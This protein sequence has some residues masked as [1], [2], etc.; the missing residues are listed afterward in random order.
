MTKKPKR[1]SILKLNSLALSLWPN[2]LEKKPN[3]IANENKRITLKTFAKDYGAKKDIFI[4]FFLF[5]Q[6]PSGYSKCNK[7]IRTFFLQGTSFKKT[8]FML[9]ILGRITLQN[10]SLR[11]KKKNCFCI[12]ILNRR[13]CAN[14]FWRKCIWISPQAKLL[15]YN[16]LD[17]KKRHWNYKCSSFL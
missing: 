12:F 4:F 3:R 13:F 14:Y 15:I 11:L 16:S 17:V 5:A 10:D 7:S 9:Q 8:S 1:D 6:I 2:C